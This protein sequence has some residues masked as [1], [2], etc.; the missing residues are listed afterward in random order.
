MSQARA[1][2]PRKPAKNRKA[3]KYDSWTTSSASRS[4]R[5]NQRARL[6]AASRWGSTA[7]SKLGRGLWSGMG[8]L[9]LRRRR[10]L[11]HLE[12]S[13][14]AAT[15]TRSNGRAILSHWIAGPLL[16]LTR[17]RTYA[18]WSSGLRSSGCRQVVDSS[19]KLAGRVEWLKTINI[20]VGFVLGFLNLT[21]M[22][23]NYANMA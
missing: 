12:G 6:Y 22:L 5:V 9:R 21:L 19:R 16:T 10:G 3:R 8:S 4:L 11:R 14:F 2:P 13:T 15:G 20:A 18:E 23:A 17:W 7:C 1:S